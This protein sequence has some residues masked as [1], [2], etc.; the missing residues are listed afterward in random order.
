MVKNKRKPMSI[1]TKNKLRDAA[2]KYHDS[3]T[4]STKLRA[5]KRRIKM[6]GLRAR[7]KGARSMTLASIRNNKFNWKKH[8]RGREHPSAPDYLNGGLWPGQALEQ[9]VLPKAQKEHHPPALDC[10][11]SVLKPEPRPEKRVG[12]RPCWR[13]WGRR[14]IKPRLNS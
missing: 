3:C 4:K 12:C 5:I 6:K 13:K 1:D 11:N 9:R 8:R 14:V 2:L 7:T 10:Y